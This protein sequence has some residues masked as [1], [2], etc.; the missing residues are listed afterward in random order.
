MSQL[1]RRGS[2]S[3]VASSNNSSGSVCKKELSRKT[4]STSFS[5]CVA[6]DLPCHEIIL[7][8]KLVQLCNS[9]TI[10]WHKCVDYIKEKN[11]RAQQDEA[12]ELLK[13]G[14][15]NSIARITNYVTLKPANVAAGKPAE[16][17][18]GRVLAELSN[19]ISKDYIV[20]FLVNI[21][22][23]L[24]GKDF[25]IKAPDGMCGD[26]TKEDALKTFIAD[27]NEYLAKIAMLGKPK[28]GR[29]TRRNQRHRQSQRQNQRQ[30]QSQ[31]QSQ[32]QN[33]RQSRRQSRR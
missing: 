17:F 22:F 4:S 11:K 13:K 12:Y 20:D 1:E 26:K 6:K 19:E 3:S 7:K 28:G 25:Q 32:R 16:T 27:V 5:G 2:V 33:Q 31:R 29:Q 10:F 23:V 30:R 8:K 21:G 18:K 15:N 9:D 24:D 14:N